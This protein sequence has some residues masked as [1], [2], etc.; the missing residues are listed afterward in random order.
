MGLSG[1]FRSFRLLA[2]GVR[3]VVTEFAG[4][5]TDLD[6]AWESWSSEA[7]HLNVGAFSSSGR[8]VFEKGH[9]VC[10]RLVHKKHA[11]TTM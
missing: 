10:P 11:D 7:G 2:D 3:G 1:V 8:I 5:W 9:P 6:G 4:D